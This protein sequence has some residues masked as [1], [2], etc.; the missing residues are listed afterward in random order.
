M[1]DL[2]NN[3][4]SLDFIPVKWDPRRFFS[5]G[6]TGSVYKDYLGS[7]NLYFLLEGEKTWPWRGPGSLQR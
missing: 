6:V 5:E 3:C 1:G 2:V 4:G 7:K